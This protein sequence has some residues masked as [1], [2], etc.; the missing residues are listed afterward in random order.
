MLKRILHKNNSKTY[1]ILKKNNYEEKFNFV[2]CYAGLRFEF[3][4]ML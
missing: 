3:P 1:I 2:R 4:V